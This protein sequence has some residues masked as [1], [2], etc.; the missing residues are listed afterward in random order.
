MPRSLLSRFAKDRR[1]NF[2]ILF[3]LAL[4]PMIG[5]MGL[6]IDYSLALRTKTALDAS[7]DA[8]VLAATTET[9]QVLQNQGGNEATAEFYGN[10]AGQNVFTANSAMVHTKTP[11]TLN[12]KLQRNGLVI[13]AKGDYTAQSPTVFGKMFGTTQINT[14]GTA[15]SSLTLPKYMKIYIAADI[16]Q[17]MGIA[18]TQTDMN[19]LVAYIQH[20]YSSHGR[21]PQ[22]DPGSSTS[23]QANG[24]VFGCHVVA[25][26]QKAGDNNPQSVEYMAHHP[27]DGYPPVTLR[28][29]DVRQS[30]QN[31]IATA[32]STAGTT[33]TISI[34]L[35]TLQEYMTSTTPQGNYYTTLSAPSTSY[36]SLQSIAAALDL[37]PN[38]SSGVGD[39]DFTNSV[40]SFVVGAV[41]A[42]GD[43]S[44]A[45]NAQS[46]VFLVTDG[47][48]DV[49]G[50]CTDGHCTKAFDPSLC[51]SMKSKGV[52]VG[53]IY[54]TYV[55]F[56]NE[57]TFRDL[58]APYVKDI[59]TKLQQC[60]SPGYYF[61][62][63]D[64]PAIQ[65][66]ANKLMAQAMNSGTLIQ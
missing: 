45:N 43:G 33:P 15:A 10:L 62:A 4:V 2:V 61:E 1:G 54:T 38:N 9:M 59:P 26:W 32:K 17:S 31:I 11:P 63:S 16:S 13:T 41:G 51:D 29:D 20:Y 53:V 35:Y 6:A 58:A 14:G 50:A 55:P 5:L 21:T 12:L 3:A 8:A 19:N 65:Q 42:S 36:D 27:M 66:A 40:S 39:S 25:P 37:G 64:G 24:C 28:I 56:P 48:Y 60:A 7:T 49:Y 23:T 22:P 18:S 47:L 44:S 46:F 34:G 57:Q 30:M 52:T